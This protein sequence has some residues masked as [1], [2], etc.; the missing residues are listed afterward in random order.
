[1]TRMINFSVVNFPFNELIL[2]SNNL[3]HM[4]KQNF[5]PNNFI[6]TRFDDKKF[7]LLELKIFFSYLLCDNSSFKFIFF[8]LEKKI[9]FSKLTWMIVHW[10]FEKSEKKLKIKNAKST[11]QAQRCSTCQIG[12]NGV[13]WTRHC[14]YWNRE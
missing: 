6:Q 4:M 11:S 8:V 1:M 5:Y 3:P 9:F 13:L 14:C 2:R 10:N 12:R 7:F